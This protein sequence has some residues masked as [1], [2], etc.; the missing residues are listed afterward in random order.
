LGVS[1]FVNGGGYGYQGGIFGGA[2]SS[3]SGSSTS[4]RPPQ[5]GR[6]SISGPGF[7]DFDLR[8]SRNVPIHENISMQ[9][10]AEAFNLLNHTII[11]GVNGTYTTF[12]G[13]GKTSNPYT[14]PNFSP[15]SGA[16]AVGCFFP[17]QGTGTSAFA[18]PSST[19]SSN[20]YGSRQLQ[21]SA[22]LFF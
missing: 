8:L 15:A 2:I 10:N 12:V 22:K 4:G 14:C 3:S 16:T 6:N 18:A 13:A 9:F 1:G 20:L 11:T 19:S 17:Y 7:N 21:V 5:V